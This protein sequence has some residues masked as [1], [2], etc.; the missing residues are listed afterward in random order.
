MTRVAAIVVL[1]G[2]AVPPKY[3]VS[4]HKM[5]AFL[6]ACQARFERPRSSIVETE[7]FNCNHA[8][9]HPFS[10]QLKIH[11]KPTPMAENRFIVSIFRPFAGRFAAG[12]GQL[13]TVL[14][15]DV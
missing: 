13:E 14:L 9:L 15:I 11:S 1:K 12:E 4:L 7:R 5:A 6:V 2:R 3:H 10:G 8:T